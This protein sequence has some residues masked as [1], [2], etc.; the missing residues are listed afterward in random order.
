MPTLYSHP[1]STFARRIRIALLEK[2]VEWE[3]RDLDM[4]GKEHKSPGYLAINPYGR[5]PA[6][7]DGDLRLAESSAILGYLEATHPEPP[8]V[9][10][11]VAGRAEVEMHTKLCDLQLAAHVGTIIFPKRFIPESRWRLEAM[12]D[13]S[14]AIARHLAVLDAPPPTPLGAENVFGHLLYGASEA[15]VR[16]T[17]ARGRVIFE[18][19][20]YTTVDP[21]QLARRAREISPAL[22]DRFRKM[23]HDTVFLGEEP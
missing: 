22:W 8:L 15:P 14:K 23:P 3:I 6:L 1:H 16:H 4:A 20:S 2:G 7:V 10:A 11:D 18:N 13:A 5:V 9:P 17:I 19:F 12:A 21:A